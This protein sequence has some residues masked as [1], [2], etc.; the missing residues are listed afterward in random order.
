MALTTGAQIGPY[1]IKSPLGEGGMGIVFRALDTKLQREVALKLLPDHFVD[2]PERL[3]RFQREAQI[4][5][6][7][8]HPNIAQIH[9]LEESGNTRCIVMELVGGETLEGRLKRGAIP[10]PE[11]LR[12]AIQIAMAL[13]AAH[14]RG[15]VH[16]DL[17]PANVKVLPNG[18]VKVLDFGLAKTTENSRGNANLSNS[19]TLGGMATNA[20]VILG[21]AAYMSPE[22]ARGETVD[23]RSDIFSFGCVLYEMLAGGRAFDGTTVS[24][25]LAS[26]LAREPDTSRLPANLSPKVRVLLLRCL[27]KDAKQRW[28]AIGDVRFEL[29]HVE[30][31]GV[32]TAAA[33]PSRQ[34]ARLAWIVAGAAALIT[35]TLT[36]PTLRHFRET[37]PPE[38]RVE[39]NTP[40]TSSP[41]EFALSPDGRHI[42]FVASGGG[43][44]RLWLRALDKIDAQPIAG[45][46]G[47]S[48]PFWSADSRSIGFNASGKLYRIDLSGG[49]R[50][51]L[52]NAGITRGGSWNASGTILFGPSGGSPLF[53]MPASGGEPV[54]VTRLDPPRQFNHRYPQ[55]LPDGNH[56][57]FYAQGESSGMYL[58]SLDGKDPKRLTAAETAGAYF[59]S[60]QVIF[61]QLGTL[62]ARRLDIARGELMGDPVI[63]A[64]AVASDLTLNFSG[65]SVS[66]DGQVAYRP[67]G[68][69]FSQLTWFDRTGKASGVIPETGSDVSFPELSP[70]GKS[71]AVVRTVPNNIDVWLIDLV[72]GGLRRFTFDTAADQLPFWSPDGTRIA[73]Q[74]N[75]KG[76]F[77]IYLKPSSGVGTDTLLLTTPNNKGALDW[78]KDGRFL[79]YFE[80][81]PKTGRDLWAL[82]MA[83]NERKPH[84]VAN[85]PFEERNGQFSPDGRFVAYETNESGLFQIVVQPFPDPT[86]KWQVSTGG[87]TLSRWRPDGKELYFISP[88]GKMMVVPVATAG[89]RFEA[90]TPVALFPTR[91]VG[92]A[93]STFKHQYAVSRD[94]RFLINQAAESTAPITLILNWKPKS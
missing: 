32:L 60:E 87:G 31:A 93:L 59:K 54:P 16:R 66:A 23:H 7:L 76:P 34:K 8:N 47:A 9:G 41:L 42:V 50:Q 56:F 38:M 81:D 17:K 89:A 78:S 68:G 67:S 26:I 64:E 1:E 51:F 35:A 3:A 73:F 29:E 19:H 44:Q 14:E 30:D 91:I 48:Y 27:S 82:G 33:T 40:S 28:Q 58:G 92:G 84:V 83:G 2:D 94:G 80:V 20:G 62:M 75:R 88:D 22:Q 43:P 79:L 4:L 39:I 24:D 74:S 86:S 52:A 11:A 12:V 10:V 36:V 18:T 6:S 61:V 70:D 13:E 90:G 49:P 63:L 65:F 69:T 55:F 72:R 37:S 57:L 15:I 53:R 45:T 25:L 77:D 5:A 85:T 71:V 21:T 46:D